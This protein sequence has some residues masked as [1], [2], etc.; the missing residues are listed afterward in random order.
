MFPIDKMLILMPN[1]LNLFTRSLIY[2][3]IIM[4]I[5]KHY[6]LYTYKIAN[7]FFLLQYY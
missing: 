5:Y 2:Y 1:V 3:T 4:Y 7:F 6:V